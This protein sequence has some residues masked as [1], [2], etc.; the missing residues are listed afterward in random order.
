MRGNQLVAKSI[1][2]GELAANDV[3]DPRTGSIGDRDVD[4]RRFA[5]R[6]ADRAGRRRGLG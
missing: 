4:H 5:D 2:V 3:V 6:R 1:E